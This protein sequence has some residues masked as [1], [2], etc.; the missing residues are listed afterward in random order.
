ML[1]VAASSHPKL[2]DIRHPPCNIE[3]EEEEV[4]GEVKR[5]GRGGRLRERGGGVKGVG[6]G[7]EGE[8][9]VKRKQGK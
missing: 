6:K 4:E 7:D 2:S 3:R 1:G 8:G 5:R 9:V